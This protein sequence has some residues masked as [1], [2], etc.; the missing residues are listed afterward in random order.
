MLETASSGNMTML[1]VSDSGVGIPPDELPHV[2]ERFYRGSGASKVSGSGI[3]LAVVTE[4]VRGHHGRLEIAS[5][6]GR[7][8]QVTVEIP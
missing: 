6:P 1:R 8:T 4:L 5:E 3:G 2:A 7:G